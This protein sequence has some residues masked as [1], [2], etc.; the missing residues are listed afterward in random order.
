MKTQIRQFSK[1]IRK[2]FTK[3]NKKHRILSG[4]LRGYKIFTNWHDYPSAI[5]GST[6]KELLTWFSENVHLNENWI[7]IGANY[8]YTV[9]A[10]AKNIGSQGS[11]HAFEPVPATCGALKETVGIN[12]FTNVSIYCLAL[13]N[14]QDF[15]IKSFK[16]SRGMLTNQDDSSNL[17]IPLISLDSLFSLYKVDRKIDGIKIDVDGQE[18]NVLFGME[19]LLRQ[20]HPKL[21]IEVHDSTY[22]AVND[23]LNKLGYKNSS[24]IYKPFYA[25]NSSVENSNIVYSVSQKYK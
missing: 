19:Q 1:F 20:Y 24:I 3:K 18:L 7:D 10:L 2:F 22:N 23:F 25:N 21:V 12:N 6:E 17:M 4:E 9:I 16:T 5:L 11:I 14:E 8:G 15:S 13:S